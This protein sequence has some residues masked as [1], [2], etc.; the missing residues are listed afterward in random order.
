MFFSQ[1]NIHNRKTKNEK[2][3]IFLR[4]SRG[5]WIHFDFLCSL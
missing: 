5:N 4:R 1:F 2:G 3:K